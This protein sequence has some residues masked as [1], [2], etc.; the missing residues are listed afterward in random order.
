MHYL[1]GVIFTALATLFPYL[2]VQAVDFEICRECHNETLD[3]FR[4]RRFLHPPFAELECAECHAAEESATQQEKN[5]LTGKDNQR[6]IQR[7][8]DSGKSDITHAFLLPGDK[9][10]DILVI[11][12]HGNDGKVFTRGIDVPP[13]ADL[14]AVQDSGRPPVISEVRVF[15]VQRAVF[16]SATIGWKTDTLTDASVRYGDEDLSQTSE[17]SPRLGRQHQIVLY[18]LKSDHNY[19]FSVVSTDLFGRRQVSKP[20]EFSTSNPDLKAPPA[21]SGSVT[22]DGQTPGIENR[23]YRHQDDYLLELTLEQPAWVRIGSVGGEQNNDKNRGL[24]D[25][26][27]HADL[28]GMVVSSMKACLNCHSAHSHPLNVR[29]KQGMTIIPEY[30]TLPDGRITCSSCHEPHGSDYYFLTRKHFERDLCIGCH[31]DMTKIVKP[32]KP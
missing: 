26:E 30:P 23:F 9:V 7:L 32:T 5:N 22:V 3:K 4:S 24:P 21:S 27:F 28:S 2:S 25:D 19:R 1:I 18:N 12:F 6:K 13:L 29:P 17:S 16:I 31:S 10:G 15:N 20:L 11:D 14:A 8:V